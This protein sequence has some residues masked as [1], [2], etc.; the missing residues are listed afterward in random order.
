MVTKLLSSS[1][2]L[3]VLE[4]HSPNIVLGID[5]AGKIVF[6]NNTARDLFHLHGEST[7]SDLMGVSWDS[8]R[9]A[10]AQTDSHYTFIRYTENRHFRFV[11]SA[12]PGVPLYACYAND[13]T[14]LLKAQIDL[15]ASEQF[16]RRV[17][18]TDPNL[19][20]VK[21]AEGRFLLVN[22]AV[23]DI[24]GTTIEGLIGKR[25]SD[26]NSNEDEV[27][28]FR[29]DDLEV[30]LQQQ[31]KIVLEEQVSSS[32]GV[33]RWFAT[34][35][36]PIQF[37]PQGRTHVLGVSTDITEL[38]KL[39]GQLGQAQKMQALGQ[40]AGGIAHD[41]N[42]LLTAIL[43]HAEVLQVLR[44]Q[45]QEVMKSSKLIYN[46][47][48]RAQQLTGQLLGFARQ[49]KNQH[50]VVD[51]RE[52]IEETIV[53]LRRTIDPSITLRSRYSSE[54]A[55]MLGDPVQIQ[56]VLMNLALNARDAIVE[57]PLRGGRGNILFETMQ[58][59]HRVVLTVSD[60]GCGMPE[61]VQRRM[62]EPF[63][64]TKEQGKGTGLG[65]AMVYGIVQNHSGDISVMSAPG[66]G[67][68]FTLEFPYTAQVAEEGLKPSRKIQR[69][70]GKGR[71]LIVDDNEDV[72]VA[73]ESMLHALGYE[74]QL[75][76]SGE[77]ALHLLQEDSSFDTAIIDLMMPGIGG[78]ETVKTIQAR[79]PHLQLIISTG[80]GQNNVIQNLID[81][82][83]AFLKKPYE[84]R[85][86]ETILQANSLSS[87]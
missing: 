81:S 24:Y 49:G 68:T 40:L 80:F 85:D 34:V 33:A 41:F 52:L 35:K 56:Q 32:Q 17:I 45:D 61:E 27:E 72:Q 23:A 3:S 11:I 74:V 73:S 71:V 76:G 75:C 66:R 25:D 70:T 15:H 14:D 28:H 12:L 6:S 67:T 1:D 37:S 39:Q 31:E 7:A 5:T 57:R 53:L 79:Y 9:S 10:I 8:V 50:T 20:F 19:I 60:D 30:I 55:R 58:R 44:P 42:N 18:D 38:R 48:T 13:I 2:W 43:G 4:E 46:A 63:F 77:E 22:Q 16:L 78:S 65:L 84:L 21:D 29:N 59:G 83:V 87:I 69:A 26:F 82:G 51:L 47:G 86:L 36:R 54:P 64:T 62:F